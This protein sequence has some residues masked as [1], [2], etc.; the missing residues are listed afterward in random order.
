MYNKFLSSEFNTMNIQ[1]IE[2]EKVN[3]YYVGVFNILKDAG[4]SDQE[5]E[6]LERAPS[7][8]AIED[9][10]PLIVD[11]FNKR[12][13]WKMLTTYDALN[14]HQ[15]DFCCTNASKL[16]SKS[17]IHS[18]LV[19]DSVSHYISNKRAFYE[20]FKEYDFIPKYEDITKDTIHTKK[21]LLDEKFINKSIIIK[22][23]LGSVSNG[24][25]VQSSYNYDEIITHINKFNYDAWTISE[26]T[27]PKLINGYITSNRIYILLSKNNNGDVNCYMYTNFM[28][29]RAEHKFKGDITNPTEFLTNYMDRTNPLADELF[30]KTRYIPNSK[31]M[32]NFTKE[33]QQIIY[34]KLSDAFNTIFE[35][36]SY[37]VLSHNDNKTVHNPSGL[38]YLANA[39]TAG[40]H[41]YGADVLID[42]KLNIKIL[43]LNGAPAMNVKTRYYK[44]HD[45]LDY[46][47]LM[48]EVFQKVVDPI[49]PPKFK[50]P[51]LNTFKLVYHSNRISQN[52]PLYYIPDTIVS[53]YPFILEAF[54]NRNFIKRTKNLH[55]KIDVFYGLREKYVTNDTNMNYYDEIL[56]FM[57]SKR[58]RNASI[59]NKV[60]GVTYFLANKG[61]L[62]EKLLKYKPKNE[63]HKYHPISEQ[64]CYENNDN[65]IKMKI[66]N[67]IKKYPNINEWIVKPVHG[68]RG[69]GIKLFRL[70]D[71]N[72]EIISFTDNVKRQ[73]LASRISEYICNYI[74]QQG[75][76][77]Y[78][79][80][81]RFNGFEFITTHEK[82]THKYWIISQY[83]NNPHLIRFKDDTFGRKYNIRFYVLLTID[84]RLPTHKNVE[85]NSNNYEIIKAYVYSEY[86][87]YFSMLEYNS[88]TIPEKY[89]GIDESK[90]LND[91][92]NLTNLE[93]VNN[94]Y[95]DLTLMNPQI[96]YDKEKAK[97]EHT[98]LLS[99]IYPSNSNAIPI[100]K[101]QAE[102]IIKNTIDAV[103]Y[104]LRP[105]NRFSKDYK[106]CFNLLAYDSLLD[107]SGNLWLIEI[108]RGPD[109]KGL[110]SNIGHDASV[111]FFDDIL[112]LTI[113][114]HYNDVVFPEAGISDWQ[115]IFIEYK[116][117]QINNM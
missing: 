99:K 22:P 75:E 49:F 113:D 44:L 101:K 68:S 94:V 109:L 36:V 84:D 14:I 76:T 102:N 95:N 65:E 13:N 24:I 57:S 54:K 21:E 7:G 30:V 60:Q 29:Y 6:E 74:D 46:F 61:R 31:Y 89:K 81:K 111:K 67:M 19:L 115:R 40:F 4:V 16:N 116:P 97:L 73:Y 93:I 69:Q 83:I 56:N 2:P 41:V 58:S 82:Q 25:I 37:D 63:I 27:I 106:G 71:A 11:C 18:R 12:G 3:L 117:I 48:E 98:T 35:A 39:V 10:F 53:N 5:L 100:I 79:T 51:E 50:Q 104:D 96:H 78:Q 107:E 108:N 88:K 20:K 85:S 87:I 103:K 59:I 23:D 8:S 92:V 66:K 34:D 26:V 45:R 17:S 32:N 33:E 9:Y 55:D 47:D 77:T 110:Y 80:V 86:M 15:L 64:C 70:D 38:P 52:L 43:E 1:P 112:K 114:H 91:M 42:D 90:Y 105:L 72:N 62:Y 28:N